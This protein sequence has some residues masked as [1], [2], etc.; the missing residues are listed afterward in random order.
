MYCWVIFVSEGNKEVFL[1]NFTVVLVVFFVFFIKC[2]Q[3]TSL[4][5][6][7]NLLVQNIQL[8]KCLCVAMETI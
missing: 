6:G 5:H 2:S 1:E 3:T 8:V 7:Q 4:L